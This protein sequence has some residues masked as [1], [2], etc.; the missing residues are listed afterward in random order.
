LIDGFPLDEEQAQD[1]LA[2]I[3]EPTAVLLLDANDDVLKR[4]LNSR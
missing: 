4:R 1:F 2:D 3:G